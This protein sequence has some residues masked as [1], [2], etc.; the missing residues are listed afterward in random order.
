MIYIF[1]TSLILGKLWKINPQNDI[2]LRYKFINLLGKT[3]VI[4]FL[5]LFLRNNYYPLNFKLLDKSNSP[6]SLGFVNQ[7]QAVDY[8]SKDSNSSKFNVDVY[9]PPV[10]S[11][12][13]DYLFTWKG[14]IQEE[15]QTKLLYTLYEADP[16]HPERLE[17][18]LARQKGIGAIIEEEKFGAITVQRRER[19]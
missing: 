5:I 17:A 14:I 9:V 13:Y 12:S 10:I 15:K 16:P 4:V 19:I 6:N 8:I 7:L 1:L 2:Q 11:Y 3:F 18:W